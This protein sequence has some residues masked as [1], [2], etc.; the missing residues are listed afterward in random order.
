MKRRLFSMLAC[1][2]M[3]SGGCGSSATTTSNAEIGKLEQQ[4]KDLTQENEEL[5]NQLAEGQSSNQPEGST[6]KTIEETES[7]GE[8]STDT[9]IQIGDVITTDNKE[10]TIKNIEF[11]Y[12][13]LPEDTSGFYTHYPADS[14]KVYIHIN[15]DVKNLQKQNLECDKIMEVTANYN[16]GYKYES[17]VVPES[18]TTGFT[19]ANITN[20]NP[21]ETMNVRFLID[22]PDETSTSS[23]SLVVNF[24]VDGSTYAY[25]IR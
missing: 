5:K 20:I 21:L 22:C 2:A 23:E 6:E 24:K 11:S 1:V 17:M 12:D 9:F 14:G 7:S 16:N 25:T 13:V 4:I 8:Q 3:I 10:I 15:A 18:S 19:Y